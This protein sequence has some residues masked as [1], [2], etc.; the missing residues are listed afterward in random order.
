MK[1]SVS[2]YVPSQKNAVE[3]K[4][5]SLAQQKTIIESS[6]DTN[7][8]VLF[9]NTTFTAILEQNLS[10]PINTYDTVD[11]VNFALAMRS[12]IKDSVTIDGKAYSLKELIKI[13]ESNADYVRECI[14]ESTKFKIWIKNPSLEHDNKVNSI[15]LRK[16]KDD[17]LRGSKLKA[18]ISDMYVY[19][20]YKFIDKIEIQG[21]GSQFNIASNISGIELIDSMDS[22]EF[23]RVVEYINKL[24]DV[25]RSF[26]KVPGTDSY[27]DI[28]PDFFVV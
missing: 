5:L 11:R 10:N 19:E 26:T 28:V 22:G 2:V 15:L 20:I 6:V 13:N 24:R 27:I 25:E 7:L 18:L 1:T 17:V 3:L 21:T 8:S 16:Y 23:V 9:F 12:Q 4:A 14:I